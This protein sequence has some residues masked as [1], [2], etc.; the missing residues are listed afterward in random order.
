MNSH[1]FQIDLQNG[2]IS[3]KR[4]RIMN[5]QPKTQSDNSLRWMA[6]AVFFAILLD[7][8][9]YHPPIARP[10]TR[11]EIT[12][13]FCGMMLGIITLA[14][15]RSITGNAGKQ[16]LYQALTSLS[17]EMR[18]FLLLIGMTTLK[19]AFSLALLLPSSDSGLV[20]T[21]SIGADTI[22][23][24][25]KWIGI[26]LM[27]WG[28]LQTLRPNAQGAENNLIKPTQK[29]VIILIALLFLVTVSLLLWSDWRG[30]VS[31]F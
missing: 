6:I 30:Y 24:A 13:E 20:R 23:L 12:Y 4:I 2:R 21:A 15:S 22:I 18:G 25:L 3:G 9:T 26:G 5:K 27:A 28:R 31:W 10:T 29:L 7:A 16:S 19:G 8:I 11:G 17:I 14:I 1:S